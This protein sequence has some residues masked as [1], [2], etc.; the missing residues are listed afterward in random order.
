MDSNSINQP[1][2]GN[3]MPMSDLTSNAIVVGVNDYQESSGLNKLKY[4]ETDATQLAEVLEDDFGYNVKLFTDEM[5]TRENIFSEL[6]KIGKS[7]DGDKFFFFF[8]GHGQSLNGE[9]YL[10]PINAEIDND[11]FSLPVNRLLDYFEKNLPHKEI[12]SIIDACHRNM[13]LNERGDSLLEHAA[14]LDLSRRIQHEQNTNNKLIKALFGC[15]YQQASYEDERLKHGVLSHFLIQKL[16]LKGHD[17]S[18]DEIAKELGEDVPD[19]VSKRFGQKQYPVFFSPLTKKEVWLGSA[20][21]TSFRKSNDETNRDV[22]F[23]FEDLIKSGLIEEYASKFE[24]TTK[25]SEWFKFYE[26][27]ND[28][29]EIS[30]QDQLRELVE[31]AFDKIKVKE[32]KTSEFRN[33]NEE[34]LKAEIMPLKAKEKV[35][36]LKDLGLKMSWIKGG[37]FEM[38]S[39]SGYKNVQPVHK[40][41]LS[42][43]IMSKYP[44]TFYQY[45]RYCKETGR[46][47]EYKE[48]GREDLSINNISWE[49]A[50]KFC[51]W[52]SIKLGRTFRLPTEAE[53]EYAARGGQKS[54]G[55]LY[56]GSNDLTEVGWYR[57]NSDRML[58]PVEER[59]PNETGLFGMSGNISEWCSDWF[60]DNYYQNSPKKDPRGPDSGTEK[61]H[62]GGSHKFNAFV[63]R[64]THRHSFSKSIGNHN[65]G[66]RVVLESDS[67]KNK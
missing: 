67:R 41:E 20:G 13:S 28:R 16:K 33:K 26:S 21:S 40:V 51:E 30:G 17:C 23:S 55:Y 18:F 62:R 66:F 32:S 39:Y 3:E 4:A 59:L 52:L 24:V 8:A 54:Q 27:I 36:F 45:S 14:T 29:F 61:V 5:A 34:N 19:Y 7:K 38:G 60:S 50:V 35:K 9:Y 44:V 58:Q 1:E 22:K 56:S 25:G 43:F 6:A 49:N 57:D 48:T 47:N 65:I 53:W 15:G 2:A 37:N 11:I 10:H 12:V 63:C 42:N 46:K 31:E 64:S